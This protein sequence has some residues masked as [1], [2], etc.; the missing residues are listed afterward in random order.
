MDSLRAQ[1]QSLYWA[2]NPKR[3][4][5]SCEAVKEF[6]CGLV[7][8]A[9]RANAEKFETRNSTGNAFIRRLYDEIH[10]PVLVRDQLVNDLLA[11]TNT[12]A[13]L[14]SWTLSVKSCIRVAQVAFKPLL[15]R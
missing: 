7:K 15:Q 3:Y 11:C 12:T 4:R 6:A 1:L 10:D 9:L 2:Y 5:V 8:Q 14:Y 13:R